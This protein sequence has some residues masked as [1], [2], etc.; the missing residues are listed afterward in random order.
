MVTNIAALVFFFI[1]GNIIWKIALPV[2]AA[3]MLG[4][5]VGSHVALK[6]GSSFIRLFFILV[7]LA[8]IAKLGYDYML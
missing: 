2:G 1:K 5:Y 8:L 6:K 7:V 4:S 3:N